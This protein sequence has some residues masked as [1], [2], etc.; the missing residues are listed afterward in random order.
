MGVCL[1]ERKKECSMGRTG[2]RAGEQKQGDR[3]IKK[4]NICSAVFCRGVCVE[5]VAVAVKRLAAPKL[6]LHIFCLADRRSQT[7]SSSASSYPPPQIYQL[8]RPWA[9]CELSKS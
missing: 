4:A 2:V 5:S 3:E 6:P 7:D 1:G 9:K 8:L